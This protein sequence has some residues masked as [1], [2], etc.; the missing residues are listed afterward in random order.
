[1]G[2]GQ[3]KIENEET[4]NRCKERKQYMERAVTARNKFAAAHVSNA[5]S[6]K[7]TG[8]ALSDFAHGEAVHPTP[9]SAAAAA[10]AAGTSSA[11]IGLNPKPTLPPPPPPLPASFTSPSPLQR[12]V[13]M[14]EFSTPRPEIKRSE[15]IIEEEDEDETDGEGSY[16]LKRRSSSKGRIRGAARSPDEVSRQAPEAVLQKQPPPPPENTGISWDFFFPTEMEDHNVER[17][18]KARRT[19]NAA[20]NEKSETP[21]TF[22]AR[23]PPPPEEATMAP[24]NSLKRAKQVALVEAKKKSLVQILVELDDCFLKASESAHEV[25]RKLEATRLHYH[26]NFADSRGHINHSERVMRVITWNRSIKGLNTGDSHLDDLDDL[27]EHDTHAS[28]LDKMLAWEKKL[29]E[30]VKAG[31]LMKVEYNRKVKSLNKLKNHGGSNA[32]SLERMK[33]AVSHLHTRYIVDLQSMD[34]TVSEINRLRDVLL[35][36]NLVALVDE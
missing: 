2:C 15:S 34:S 29:Y 23:P 28:V 21:E 27:E 3:S 8:A 11:G 17:E 10:A 22:S 33:A 19:E 26:S 13:T 7:N 1:M 30:E 16:S 12:A 31:E 25:S 32:D 35:Y 24:S 5:M 18:E 20:K 9:S 6:L 4:V 14:P 36:P